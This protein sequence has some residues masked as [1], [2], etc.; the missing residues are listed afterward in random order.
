M[1]KNA[2]DITPISSNALSFSNVLSE[3]KAARKC[4]YFSSKLVCITCCAGVSSEIS[5]TK[6][7]RSFAFACKLCISNLVLPCVSSFCSWLTCALNPTTTPFLF[8]CGC[9]L[10]SLNNFVVAIASLLLYFIL[11]SKLSLAIAPSLNN[12]S[13]LVVDLGLVFTKPSFKSK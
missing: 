4:L 5:I 8:L 13:A 7:S 12:K 11:A 10:I 1:P 6:S 2:V 9:K 3:L